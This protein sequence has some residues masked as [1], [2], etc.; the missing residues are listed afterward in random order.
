M[1]FLSGCTG[2]NYMNIKN[3]IFDVD[4]TLWDITA[5]AANAW[6]SV[7]LHYGVK[8]PPITSLELK[9]LF[10]KPMD[11][12][13]DKLFVS[14]TDAQKKLYLQLCCETEAAMLEHSAENFLYNGVYETIKALS[15]H[16]G[17]YIVSNCQCGYIETFLTKSKLLSYFT[18]FESFGATGLQKGANIRLIIDRN[19]LEKA[20]YIGDIQSDCDSA[21][22]AGIP[23]IHAAYGFG[24][25][26]NPDMAIQSFEELLDLI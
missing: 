16:F 23:F 1:S 11:Y 19:S 10:G 18:D 4:G 21:R 22:E 8:R 24:R 6:N 9:G 13:A 5:L 15:K 2:D 3:M 20:V 7:I 25:V 12:I 14:S 26:D 17:L